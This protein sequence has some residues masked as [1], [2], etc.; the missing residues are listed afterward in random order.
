MK[1]E[2]INWRTGVVLAALAIS[3]TF[4]L[5]FSG[6]IL[7]VLTI[8]FYTGVYA[9]AWDLLFGYAGEVNFGPTFLI[10]LGAYASGMCNSY[11][12][13][14]LWLCVLIGTVAAVIGGILLAG[15][16]LRLRGPYFGLVTLVSVLLL[17]NMIVVFAGYTGGEIGLTLNDILTISSAG[18]FYWALGLAAVSGLVLRIIARSSLGMILEASGQDP[19]ATEALGFSVT[20]FKFFAFILSALVSGLAG[21][22]TVF[23][24][25]TASP[26]TV[27]AVAVT[28]QIIIATIVGGRRSIVG[29]VLGAIFLIAAGEVLRPIGQLSNTVV[30]VIALAVLVFAPNGFIGLFAQRRERSA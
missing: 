28:V 13:L 23:Y 21:S 4:P 11:L 18:N 24:L 17:G 5:Y 14:P 10:G 12:S 26:G 25:G 20:K 19:T 8:A 3:A 29:P 9:M 2:W 27:V 16:A 6:Y 15:P 7:G 22:M 1:K 30:A